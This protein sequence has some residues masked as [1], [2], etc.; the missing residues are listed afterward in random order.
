MMFIVGSVRRMKFL[1]R[2]WGDYTHLC[3]FVKGRIA[4]FAYQCLLRIGSSQSL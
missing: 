3:G 2:Y 1:L 4:A